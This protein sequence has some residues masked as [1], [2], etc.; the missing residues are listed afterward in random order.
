MPPKTISNQKISFTLVLTEKVKPKARPRL[1]ST[2]VHMPPDYVD[3]Q[4]SAIYELLSGKD[5][6]QK[7]NPDYQFPID[8]PI[9]VSVALL[10][11][12]QGDVDNL[13][14]GILDVMVKA[15]VIKNDCQSILKGASV[16]A[17][18]IP[19]ELIKRYN[20]KSVA[21]IRVKSFSESDWR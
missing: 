12:H 1:S 15:E 17:F 11:S 20:S 3:W 5:V 14:G 9:T 2:N 8:S 6:V 13:L 19:K 7:I 16:A 10:G 4:S 18:S 21:L